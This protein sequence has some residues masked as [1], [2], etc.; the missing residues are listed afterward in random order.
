VAE[1]LASVTDGELDS[2]L[3]SHAT[4]MWLKVALVIG[5]T[6]EQ[7]GVHDE[8]RVGKRLA[9]LVASGR[10]ESAGDINQWRFSEVRL[11]DAD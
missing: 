10:L 7:S 3:L 2:I 11:P 4:S 5:R 8:E 1:D 6:M 9:A